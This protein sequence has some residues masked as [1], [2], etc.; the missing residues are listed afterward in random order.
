MKMEKNYV[1]RGIADDLRTAITLG[2]YSPGEMI[3]SENM[4]AAQYDTSRVTVRKAL[5]LLEN[6]GLLRPQHGKGYFVMSP[7]YSRFQLDFIDKPDRAGLHYLEI[8]V[9]PADAALAARFRV[10]ED[11]MLVV[12]RRLLLENGEPCAYDE[13]YFLYVKGE[14][15]IERELHYAEFPD[16]FTDRYG[17]RAIWTD[18]EIKT[19]RPA[20][21]VSEALGCA[22][23]E[24]LLLVSRTIYTDENTPIG[25]GQRWYAPGSSGLNA[26]SN[27]SSHSASAY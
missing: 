1:Y 21:R 9:V 17:A 14:P 8:S 13:K 25:F 19:G 4:L 26:I 24:A 5:D 18:M 27:Y 10:R 7:E 15:L 16:V 3:P 2:K 11:T 20:P 12:I 22:Q 23:D 6:E